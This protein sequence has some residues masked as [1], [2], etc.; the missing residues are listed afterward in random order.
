M[1]VSLEDL[2]SLAEA[3]SGIP[4]DRPR[5]LAE[6]PS[7]SDEG[8]TQFA[9]YYRFFHEFVKR[10]SPTSVLEVGTYKG[11]SAAHLAL[12]APACRVLTLDVDPE[13]TRLVRA[14][15]GERG[16]TNLTA[17]VRPSSDALFGEA[18][19]LAPFDVLFIDAVHDFENC[20]GDY[21]RYRPLVNPGGIIFFDD[22]RI[23]RQME[24]AWSCIAD[25]KVELPSLHYTGFGACKLDP[26]VTPRPLA[27]ARS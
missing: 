26:M 13:A 17:I 27:E 1:N 3:L 7:A 2:K 20:Y 16:L 15:A 6:M 10:F 21:L 24:A 18:E 9:R 8:Q 4:D 23:D 5:W 22:V 19:R 11:S 12:A 14:V 25:P